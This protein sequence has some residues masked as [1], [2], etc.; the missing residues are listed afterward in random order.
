M[1]ETA[2]NVLSSNIYAVAQKAIQQCALELLSVEAL[3]ECMLQEMREQHLRED[4][5]SQRTLTRMAQRLCSRV[6][7]NAWRSS[8][9][10]ERNNAFANL[11][12][13]LEWSLLHSAYARRLQSYTCAIEDVLHSTLEILATLAAQKRS[14]GPDDPAAFLKWTQTILVRQAHA[15]WMSAIRDTSLSLNEHEER[16]A[17][18]FVDVRNGNPLDEVLVRE[19]RK[20]LVDIVCSLRNPRYRQVLV[21]TYIV[22][23]DEQ[24]VARQ[25]GVAVQDVYVWRH[26]A[27]KALRQEPAMLQLLH[28]LRE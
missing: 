8:D 15:F 16:F 3:V 13:F 12:R 19:M 14:S 7:Y 6:L 27:L 9:S 2:N 21:A 23:I 25:L 28:T 10:E 22:D 11:R 4:S 17:E 5:L 26:R 20:T 1:E 24:E 18:Q